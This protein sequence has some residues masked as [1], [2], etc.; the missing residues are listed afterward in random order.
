MK[1]SE[2]LII[3]FGFLLLFTNLPYVHTESGNLPNDYNQALNLEQPLK[4][5]FKKV[6]E[7]TNYVE[8]GWGGPHCALEKGGSMELLFNGLYNESTYRGDFVNEPF[9][10]VTF[11][12]ADGSI[13]CTLTNKSNNAIAETL[14]LSIYPWY[15]GILTTVNWTYHDE[16][17]ESSASSE[18]MEGT[19]NISSTNGFRT[20]NY[21]QNSGAQK[22]ILVYNETS[23][24]LDNWNTSFG[25]YYLEATLQ[26]EGIQSYP[27]VIFFGFCTLVVSFV[28]RKIRKFKKN[29][30]FN[31]K[32]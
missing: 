9:F 24:F 29:N 14:I 17:A 25:N 18:L 20:Y 22:T 2:L 32:F 23:G 16:T 15:P 10:N 4:Y 13:N 5:K 19:L 11:I 6:N 12:H 28:I 30:N 7:T 27:L 8:F 3:S 26:R 31:T 1:K 21:V